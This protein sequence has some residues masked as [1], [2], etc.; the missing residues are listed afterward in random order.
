MPKA[1]VQLDETGSLDL[2]LTFTSYYKQKIIVNIRHFY[3]KKTKKR[4]FL[5]AFYID[6]FAGM[7]YVIE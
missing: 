7:K 5:P 2:L 6:A 1:F 4:H 3:I